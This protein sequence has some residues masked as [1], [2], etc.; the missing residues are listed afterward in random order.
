[1]ARDS[2]SVNEWDLATSL[3]AA[4][5]TTIDRKLSYI[6][7]VQ[8]LRLYMMLSSHP[9]S[10]KPGIRT[11]VLTGKVWSKTLSRTNLELIP[12]YYS[13]SHPKCS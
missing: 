12:A 9:M 4:S 7:V 5:L 10:K 2:E 6:A 11:N 8:I 1:M 3:V 13:S